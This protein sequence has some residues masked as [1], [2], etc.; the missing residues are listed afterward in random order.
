M[1][2][3]SSRVSG[4]ALNAAVLSFGGLVGGF[5]CG[6]SGS[7]SAVVT[8]G[9][10]APPAGGGLGLAGSSAATA[11]D[12]APTPAINPYD[13]S[14]VPLEVEPPADFRGKRVL[15]VAGRKSHGPGDH[16]FFAGSAILTN[17]LKQT[18][19]VWPIMAR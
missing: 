3:R 15:I 12:K 5:S 13:Q 14:Q 11:Q 16:E 18:P 1:R 9:P 17:L 10:L 6:T 2:S 8:G 7:V 19:G 4:T